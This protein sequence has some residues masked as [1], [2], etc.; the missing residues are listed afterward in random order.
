MA[1]Q[2]RLSNLIVTI[3]KASN[4]TYNSDQQILDDW[5]LRLREYT[6][7]MFFGSQNMKISLQFFG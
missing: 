3:S 1:S 5:M 6:L 4:L 2:S 7:F